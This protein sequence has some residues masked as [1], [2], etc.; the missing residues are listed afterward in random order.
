MFTGR[1]RCNEE[2]IKN[3][4]FDIIIISRYTFTNM[5]QSIYQYS[6]VRTFIIRRLLITIIVSFLLTIIIF[7]SNNFER[8]S[9]EPTGL[10]DP[11]LKYIPDE[12]TIMQLREEL[13]FD[14]PLILQYF[15]WIGNIF[16]GIL[17]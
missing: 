6:D 10:V 9:G 1:E 8:L 16:R 5:N 17:G 15:Y 3:Q 7:V 13:H 14:K 12:L 11:D 2:R 4:H